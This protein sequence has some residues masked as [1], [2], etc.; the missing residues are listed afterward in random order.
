VQQSS[1][2][3]RECI[4]VLA[5]RFGSECLKLDGIFHGVFWGSLE[6]GS[7]KWREAWV[8]LLED[9]QDCGTGT[10]CVDASLSSSGIYWMRIMIL[11]SNQD[12]GKWL[13]LR[14]SE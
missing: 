10:W 13:E 4:F 6:R 1:E 12:S 7:T 8:W 2:E 14:M 3:K 5:T 9:V 11:S